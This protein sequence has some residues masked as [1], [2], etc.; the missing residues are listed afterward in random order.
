[1]WVGI[2]LRV[3]LGVATLHATSA[4]NKKGNANGLFRVFVTVATI[5][6]PNSRWFG[7]EL[8]SL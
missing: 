8:S 6:T 4:S 2:R 5:L 1:M 7:L 3:A